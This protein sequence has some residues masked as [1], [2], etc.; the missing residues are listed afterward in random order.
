MA[1]ES[2]TLSVDETADDFQKLLS[3]NTP[4]MDDAFEKMLTAHTHT[5]EVSRTLDNFE[6]QPD[7]GLILT[8]CAGDWGGSVRVSV[9]LSVCVSE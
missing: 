5:S 9:C 8:R 4:A 2:H 6:A 3:A 7:V 1:D